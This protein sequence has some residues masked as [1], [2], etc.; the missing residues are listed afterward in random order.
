LASTA[1]GG[2]PGAKLAS[3][4]WDLYGKGDL[5]GAERLLAQAARQG[6]PPWV[7]YALGF[8][9]VGLGS[10]QEAVRSWEHVRAAVPE[11]EPVYLDLADVYIQ[12]NDADRAIELLREAE[13]RWPT[14]ADVLNAL[15]TIQVRRNALGD[16][17]ETFEKAAKANS[18]DPLAF[19]NLGRTY[20]LRYFAMRRFSRPSSR[21]VDN[22]ELLNKAIENYEV[23]AKLGGP[24][25]ADARAAID[26]LRN[27]R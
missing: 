18:S 25:E 2:G 27:I 24:Y 13:K 19:F 6:A 26:R 9:Q 3:D 4:G 5:Q 17:I 16:A 10:P 12:W 20:E 11:F 15:G 8:A 22:P 23:C 14:D 1:K 21:W 7:H